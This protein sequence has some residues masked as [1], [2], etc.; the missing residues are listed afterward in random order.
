MQEIKIYCVF[1]WKILYLQ[2]VFVLFDEGSKHV[3]C[4]LLLSHTRTRAKM[5][6]AFAVRLLDFL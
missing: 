6:D 3:K 5:Y 4:S 2:N 1:V